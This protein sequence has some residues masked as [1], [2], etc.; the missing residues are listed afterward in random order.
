[1]TM[2]VICIADIELRVIRYNCADA[3]NHRVA[4]RAPV[5]HIRSGNWTGNPLTFAIR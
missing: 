5:L 1:M 3:C 4:A 2:R